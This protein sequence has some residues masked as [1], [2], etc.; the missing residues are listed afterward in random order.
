MEEKSVRL[1][2]EIKWLKSCLDKSA[3]ALMVANKALEKACS[4]IGEGSTVNVSCKICEYND[5][6]RCAVFNGNYRCQDGIKKYLIHYAQN[7]LNGDK[8]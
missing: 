6:G 5:I 3:T 2:K 4:I 8:Q 7:Q 1:E